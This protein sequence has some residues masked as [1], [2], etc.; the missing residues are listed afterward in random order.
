MYAGISG[1]VLLD[2]LCLLVGLDALEALCY[3]F[4]RDPKEIKDY[5]FKRGF[6]WS[7]PQK[8]FRPI[9]YDQ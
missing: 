2:E 7:E 8:Q 5:L 1:M 6:V 9:G 4:S 3:A